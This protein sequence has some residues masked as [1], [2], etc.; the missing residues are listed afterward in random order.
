MNSR[1]IQHAEKEFFGIL[2]Q[3]EVARHRF[4]E[5][6]FTDDSV[7]VPILAIVTKFDTFVQDVLQKLEEKAD[8]E[9]N[10]ITEEEFVKQATQEAKDRFDMHYR[11]PLMSLPY[12]PKAVLALSESKSLG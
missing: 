10:D 12:P 5:P 4:L 1:P 11:I 6:R 8:E 2:W 7:V 9:G 3:G